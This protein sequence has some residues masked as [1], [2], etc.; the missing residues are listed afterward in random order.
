[1]ELPKHLQIYANRIKRI[2]KAK[3]A[4]INS[5]IGKEKELLQ[6]LFFELKM[7]HVSPLQVDKY[8]RVLKELYKI[9]TLSKMNKQ[10]AREVAF[11]IINKENWA[12]ETKTALLSTFKSMLRILQKETGNDYG[13]DSIV[14]RQKMDVISSADIPTI[15]EVQSMITF[16]RTIK[17]KTIIAILSITGLRIGEL[18]S[19]QWQNVKFGSDGV[20]FEVQGKTGKRKVLISSNTTAYQLFVTYSKMADTDA[21]YFVFSK[22]NPPNYAKLRKQF[23]NLIKKLKQMNLIRKSLRLTFHT[24]RHYA[25]S[26]AVQEGIPEMYIKRIFGWSKTTK[27]VARY[28]K[29]N[30]EIAM[31]FMK[32][33]QK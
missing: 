9:T 10:K 32:K 12:S 16:A 6:I 3:Q 25:V 1:M 20:Y 23:Y 26:H 18:L 22:A 14:V 15:A 7:R 17:L 31:N 8:M 2:D 13:I 21:N 30:D 27:M 28:T 5:A 11:Y 4:I 33:M 24:L 29:L 19:L